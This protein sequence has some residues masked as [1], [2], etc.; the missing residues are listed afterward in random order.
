MRIYPLDYKGK[1][2]AMYHA[3]IHLRPAMT[4]VY[5]TLCD[6][7]HLV[8]GS[9]DIVMRDEQ[10]Y[11]KG[12]PVLPPSGKKNIWAKW[13]SGNRENYWWMCDYAYGINSEYGWRFKDSLPEYLK[14]QDLAINGIALLLPQTHEN[15]FLRLE[16]F[17]VVLPSEE[18]IKLGDDVVKKNV[19]EI[20]RAFYASI[21]GKVR[22][23]WTDREAPNFM[24]PQLNLPVPV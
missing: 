19:V 18:V 9:S 1:M 21:K 8:G 14:I 16:E 2:A 4:A 6:V 12:I 3:D 17:P 24:S 10:Y 15:G 13:I 20:Y 5:R 23:K 7:V 22:M 11:Y